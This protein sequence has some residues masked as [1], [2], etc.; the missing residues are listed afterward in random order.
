MTV[1]RQ[2]SRHKNTFLRSAVAWLFSGT[3]WA[4]PWPSM[5]P[6]THG[7]T[8][9]TSVPWKAG[10]L[11]I[12]VSSPQQRVEWGDG[13]GDEHEGHGLAKEQVRCCPP[14]QAYLPLHGNEMSLSQGSEW[15]GGR[16][17]QSCPWHFFW[18]CQNLG[19][20][21]A[22]MCFQPL[23]FSLSLNHRVIK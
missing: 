17:N 19:K 5:A 16:G 4:K 1:P 18:V 10:W 21:S 3:S 6:A 23:Y 8:V 7:D 14:P 13:L 15:A 11:A 12:S 20:P 22:L 9:V 2:Q